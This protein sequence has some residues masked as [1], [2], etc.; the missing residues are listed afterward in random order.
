MMSRKKVVFVLD[1]VLHYQ[2]DLFAE[3]EVRLAER[4]MDFYLLSGRPAKAERG[5]VGLDAKVVAREDKFDFAEYRLG[6]F[7]LRRQIGVVERVA[8]LR[9][10]IVVC[11][12]HVGNWTYWQLQRIK[13]KLGFK[14]VSWQCGYEYNR[15]ALKELLLSVFVP[16]FDHHLA[17]HT[18]AMKYAL[19]HGAERSQITVVHN[20][21]NESR[22]RIV[23][24][25]EAKA[26]VRA[27]HPGIGRRVMLLYVGSILREK[28]IE[29]VIQ[30]L[31][32]MRAS[33]ELV[34]VVVGD[35]PYLG[36]LKEEFANRRDVIF[37]GQE[38]ERVGIYFD[39]SD[40]FILPG[41]GGLAINEAMAHGLPVVSAYADGS[42]DDLVLDGLT[43]YRLRE[44][45]DSE[46]ANV[47]VR[48]LRSEG[49]RMRMGREGRQLVLSRFSFNSFVSRIVDALA[50]I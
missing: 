48:L 22:I 3:L 30:A 37:V 24:K 10:H 36:A 27:R 47:L 18:N 5:R 45:S 46:I 6:T 19:Q 32:R 34:F 43:G 1:R 4:S 39:A 44:G 11:A 31:D 8:F 41:T 21:I 25:Q 26:A 2:R 40:I 12:S 20:T 28:R 9:P 38:I 33:D 42:A 23:D 50:A 13:A 16:G 49:E 14:L 17:Y 29:C 35:G 15:N 7:T